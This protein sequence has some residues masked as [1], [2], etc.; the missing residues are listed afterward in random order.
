M[1]RPGTVVWV[2]DDMGKHLGWLGV[3]PNS[4]WALEASGTVDSMSPWQTSA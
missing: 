1:G 2:R 4:L 3:A